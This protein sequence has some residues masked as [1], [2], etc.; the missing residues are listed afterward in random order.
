MLLHSQNEFLV[1]KFLT[2]HN[3]RFLCTV[4]VDGEEMTCYV[5]SSCKLGNLIDLNN[6]TVLLKQ[7]TSA[8]T[9]TKYAVYAVK[10][11]RNYILLNLAQVNNVIA[12]QL[13]RR[14]F[15]SLGQRKSV[16][17]EKCVDG[18]RADLFI[19]DTNTLVEVKTLLSLE[20]NAHFPSVHSERAISQ[21]YKLD[22]L[23]DQGYKVSYLIVSLTPRVKEIQINNTSGEFYDLFQ[24]CVQ[25]GMSVNAV[26]I[27]MTEDKFQIYST[28]KVSY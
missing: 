13:H 12:S 1:G 3:S 2:E 23:L 19:Q 14:Y 16:L 27:Y 6:R 15:S 8:K 22:R 24:R 11:G 21:L 5:P 10:Y 20:R 25:K 9:R 28:I 4:C 18:Y 17:Q 26:S 7:N